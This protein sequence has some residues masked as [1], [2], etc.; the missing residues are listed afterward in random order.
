MGTKMLIP[1]ADLDVAGLG[2]VY[3]GQAVEVDD[4]MAGVAPDPRIEKASIELNEAIARQ[5][6]ETAAELREE[7]IDLEHGRGLLARGWK[8][9]SKDTP[10]PTAPAVQPAETKEIDK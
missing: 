2:S 8:L 9:A 10:K 4:D 1:P 3:A 7:I 6:H 5:D